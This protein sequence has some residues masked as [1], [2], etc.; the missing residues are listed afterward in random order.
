MNKRVLAPVG[1]LLGGFALVFVALLVQDKF[2]A[3][4]QAPDD[5][6]LLWP[7][8]K[9]V[10]DFSLRTQTGEPFGVEQLTGHWTLWYFGYTQCPDVCPVTLTVLKGVHEALERNAPLRDSLQSVFVSVDPARDDAEQLQKYLA[11]F[12]ADLLAATGGQA[13]LSRISEQLGVS[14]TAQPADE[15]GRY[16]VDHTAAILL[17]DPKARLVAWFGA[18]HTAAQIST[19]L[20]RIVQFVG[21]AE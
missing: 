1:A 16:V 6:P 14:F 8:P 15:Q 11:F 18:P 7:D 20:L 3:A 4:P 5:L 17:T 10:G 19:Q 13:E 9:S 2:T 21:S 12:G